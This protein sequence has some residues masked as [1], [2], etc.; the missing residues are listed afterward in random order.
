MSKMPRNTETSTSVRFAADPQAAKHRMSKM[1]GI[2]S[3]G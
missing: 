3:P 1:N 2:V